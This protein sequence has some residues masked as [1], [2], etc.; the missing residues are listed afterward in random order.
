MQIQDFETLP[1][2]DAAEARRW[3][4]WNLECG[5]YVLDAS[6][7]KNL[8]RSAILRSST[9]TAFAR[10]IVNARLEMPVA[11][12]TIHAELPLDAPLA[13]P[14]LYEAAI[15]AIR[16]E[17]EPRPLEMRSGCRHEEL[18][19]L[20][21]AIELLASDHTGHKLPP[22]I[23]NQDPNLP[24]EQSDKPDFAPIDSYDVMV[25]VMNDVARWY[26]LRATIERNPQAH[27]PDRQGSYFA[28]LEVDY[29]RTKRPMRLDEAEATST[30]LD[31]YAGAAIGLS[32]SP[33]ECKRR[34]SI[35]RLAGKDPELDRLKPRRPMR[36]LVRR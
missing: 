3:I 34:L 22:L 23:C 21:S 15:A 14:G 13:G 31:F 18:T 33:E 4:L 1:I 7:K 2:G 12:A 32:L 19:T 25:L 24:L 30:I 17:L 16:R 27:G 11:A 6:G 26:G 20:L 8:R 5:A 28:R 10:P 35:F 29:R 36:P 9:G